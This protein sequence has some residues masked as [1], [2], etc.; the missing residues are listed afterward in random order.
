MK[1]MVETIDLDKDNIDPLSGNTIRIQSRFLGTAT[2]I[3]SSSQPSFYSN[4]LFYEIAESEISEIIFDKKSSP[5]SNCSCSSSSIN[6]SDEVMLTSVM[7]TTN[8]EENNNTTTSTT[9]T[10]NTTSASPFSSPPVVILDSEKSPMALPPK[11]RKRRRVLRYEVIFCLLPS[12]DVAS[13]H[14][15]ESID[16]TRQY[17]LFPRESVVESLN[18]TPPLETIISF[19][20]PNKAS[21]AYTSKLDEFASVCATNLPVIRQR[22]R[23]TDPGLQVNSF[24]NSIKSSSS[25]STTADNNHVASI[26]LSGVSKVLYIALKET[27]SNF[28]TMYAKMAELIKSHHQQISAQ[29]LSLLDEVVD[30]E[31]LMFTSMIAHSY[32]TKKRR[33]IYLP[34]IILVEMK[35]ETNDIT[36]EH[37]DTTSSFHN[38]RNSHDEEDSTKSSGFVKK[39]LYC[40]SKSTPMWRRGP[41]GAGTLCNA[42]GVKW[43]HGKIL[44]GKDGVATP[45]P[46][47]KKKNK[48]T[49]TT[50]SNNNNKHKRDKPLKRMST[51]HIPS[52][53]TTTSMNE[54][55]FTHQST[56]PTTSS[57]AVSALHQRRHTTDM[58]LVDKF[59][60]VN[61]TYALT[62]AG[63]DAV[64]AAAVLTLLKR[65]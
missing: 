46:I 33:K 58:S 41:Q 2:I 62:T 39:C 42:C 29:R 47:N 3:A 38:K 61:N 48:R 11:K 57:T 45:S 52:T 53:T 35:M 14:D 8:N 32:M 18:E 1:Q 20:L 19:H 21:D 50:S 34:L 55:Y 43:K 36:I 6:S 44:C 28:E 7:M 17:Y 51:G 10:T 37:E 64:E 12:Q 4:G 54:D 65:S 16:L 25:Q 15:E 27:V 59:G 40:G 30:E 13:T 63:V 24:F 26:R 56:S 60:I 49:T 9:T 5:S 22:R 31:D 23:F